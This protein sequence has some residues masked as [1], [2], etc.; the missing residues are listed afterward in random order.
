M[1]VQANRTSIN[2]ANSSFRVV[3]LSFGATY[4]SLSIVFSHSSLSWV[5]YGPVSFSSLSEI[6]VEIVALTPLLFPFPFSTVLVHALYEPLPGSMPVSKFYVDSTTGVIG[7]Y[8]GS[9]CHLRDFLA[10]FSG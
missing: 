5:G 7:S 4:G 10:S 8:F 6:T 9:L 2:V 3:P 1:S